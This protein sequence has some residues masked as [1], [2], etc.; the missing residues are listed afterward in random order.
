MVGVTTWK[1]Y[2]RV[3]AL[4]RLRTNE[5]EL[6][7]RTSWNVGRIAQE[8]RWGLEDEGKKDILLYSLGVNR[9]L[10]GFPS[11]RAFE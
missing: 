10:Q 1:L 9:E 5:L 3:T 11:A 8:N 7:Q 6:R 4:G 2:L